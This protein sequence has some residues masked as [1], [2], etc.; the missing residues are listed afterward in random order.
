MAALLAPNKALGDSST[1]VVVNHGQEP[2]VELYIINRSAQTW[3]NDLLAGHALQA[4]QQ[5]SVSAAVGCP[6]K[7]KAIYD[8]GAVRYQQTSGSGPVV[9]N[10]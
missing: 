1:I 7:I 4:S 2:I 9:F 10:H 6:C 3:G 5:R 8:D